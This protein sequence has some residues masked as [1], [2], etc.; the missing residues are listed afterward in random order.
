MT[1]I[2]VSTAYGVPLLRL[3]GPLTQRNG[4]ELA[5]AVMSQIHFMSEDP[6]SGCPHPLSLTAPRLLR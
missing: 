6:D 5:T 4:V 2:R 1:D 3:S